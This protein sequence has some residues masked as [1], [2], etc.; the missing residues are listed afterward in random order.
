MELSDLTTYAS[1]NYQIREQHKWEDFPG[2]SVLCHPKTGKWIALLMRQWDTETGTQIERCDLKCGKDSLFTTPRPY[3]SDPVRMHGSKWIGIAFGPRT[4][5]HV[6]FQ[7]FDKAVSSEDPQ[8]YTIVLA[9][10][11]PAGE[12]SYKDTALPF[13]GSR[14]RAPADKPP[15][16]LRE[17]KRLYE[18]GR[19]TAESRAKNFYKQAVFM[20]DYEDDVPWSGD[21]SC[22][23]PTYSDLT[24]KQLRG[25]FSWRSQVRKGNYQWI[26][27]SAAYI[28]LYELLNGIGTDSPEDCLKKL[29]E[30]E[31]G[32]L[33]SGIGDKRM[34]QN[35]H[36]WMLEYA[37]LHELPVEQTLK[38]ADPEM[39]EKDKA[40]MIL[41]APEAYSEEEV[42]SALCT[43]DRKKI[44][45]SP[46]M[47]IS[48][49]RGKQLFSEVWKKALT[50]RFM[51]KDLFTLC[52][53][54][55]GTRR[56][57]PLANAVYYEK[58][59]PAEKDYF[60]DG[61][62]YYQCRNGS[63]KVTAY[64]NLSFDKARFQGLLHE[65]DVLLRRYLKTGRYLKEDPADR[66]AVPF[67]E[68]V[69]EADKK[70]VIEASRPKITIDL[71]SLEQIRRDAAGTRDSLLTEEELDRSDSAA[72][73]ADDQAQE[74][75]PG[76]AAQQAQEVLPGAAAQQAQ[77]ILPGAAAV[78]VPD[79][80]P[81]DQVQLQILL[82]LLSGGDGSEILK[83]SH[84]MPSIAADF[85]NEA[86]FDE[87]GDTVLICEDNR[88][89]LVEDYIEDLKLLLTGISHE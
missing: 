7:L 1:E 9:S 49:E 74:V 10:Q 32:F 30:F 16:R 81:L 56:W 65:A 88:L 76:T 83:A 51:Q 35:L 29:R 4:E 59:K 57:Y 63:W 15:E 43:F 8:G 37:V 27:A 86:L 47:T 75:P 6:V 25:Y 12:S 78:R 38:Y 36:Q 67:I 24:T 26:A 42:F 3:L 33:D 85:I 53:G 22:Y 2:F 41:R 45:K 48:P 14:Y 34:R 5:S 11:L 70:A 18:Y 62:R 21:F 46:V 89:M 61:C 73:A 64:D 60:L 68:M 44:T 87:I 50:Y 13:A 31:I 84:Q 20:Q 79:G 55:P 66:W 40:L 17:M 39:I 58:S 28:Y 72:E 52:F 69:I 23:F 80:L 19:E 71:S 82:S 77:E 54:E